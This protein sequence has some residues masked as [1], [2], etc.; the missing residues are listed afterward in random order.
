[1]CCVGHVAVAVK[2]DDHDH[3]HD[4]VKSTPAATA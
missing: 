2:V 1:V 3:D 4:H